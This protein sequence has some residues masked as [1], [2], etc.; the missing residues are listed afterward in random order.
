[1]GGSAAADGQGGAGGLDRHF[2]IA[3]AAVQHHGAAAFHTGGA[4]D[5]EGIAAAALE[6]GQGTQ[7][8]VA[9]HQVDGGRGQPGD[10]DG[11]QGCR[12][13]GGI[14]RVVHGQR[15]KAGRVVD[16]HGS[17]ETLHAAVGAQVDGG[18]SR[19]G[20]DQGGAGAL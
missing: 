13:A 14:G 6:D 1:G 10:P 5:G 20:K 18:G 8:R 19:V 7:D 4:G 15:S 16:R 2:I 11:A 9:A 17:L 3:G 12:A